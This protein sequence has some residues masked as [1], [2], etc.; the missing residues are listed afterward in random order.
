MTAPT[1]INLQEKFS[2]FTDQWSPK[3]IGVVNDSH[4][5]IARVEGE[6]I[7]HRH[8]DE[9]E[10]FLVVKGR[11][12]LRFRDSEVALVEGEMCIVPRGVEHQPVADGEAW[13]LLV[14]P[15][16]TLNTGNVRNDRTVADLETI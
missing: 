6:F 3:L 9:D 16:T 4:V 12:V 13:I 15:G 7:W 8:D 2:H 1:P 5:K 10:M 11:L 14:E